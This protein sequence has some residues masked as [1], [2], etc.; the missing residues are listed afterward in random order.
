MECSMFAAEVDVLSATRSRHLRYRSIAS[1]ITDGFG[2]A[3]VNSHRDSVGGDIDLS[4]GTCDEVSLA[5][6]ESTLTALA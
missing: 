2:S 3:L 5:K 1:S 4:Y 6:D